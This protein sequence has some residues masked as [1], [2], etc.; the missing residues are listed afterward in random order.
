MPRIYRSA[1]PCY[2][3][4]KRTPDCHEKGKCNSDT[5][6]Y[7]EW[8]ADSEVVLGATPNSPAKNKMLARYGHYKAM[9][10]K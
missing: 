7:H 6:T 10:R 1:C 8:K 5:Q 3:C 2:G 9:G 4:Q